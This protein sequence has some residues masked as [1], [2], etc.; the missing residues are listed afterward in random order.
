MKRLPIWMIAVMGIL[1]VIM[2]WSGLHDIE[3]AGSGPA[4]IGGVWIVFTLVCAG[5]AFAPERD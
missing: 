3:E 5:R 4:I 1:G 2:L